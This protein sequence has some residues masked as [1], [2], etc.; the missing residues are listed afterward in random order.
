[1]RFSFYCRQFLTR[2]AL[3]VIAAVAVGSSCSEIAPLRVLIARR[4]TC[5][6][7]SSILRLR[8]LN[9]LCRLHC[10]LVGRRVLL[11]ALELVDCSRNEWVRKCKLR[12]ESL[13]RFPFCTLVNEVNKILI[14]ATHLGVEVLGTGYS[15]ATA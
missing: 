10:L 3:C 8:G 2:L 12:R 9:T 6:G 14:G 1:M 4:M 5:A 11:E 13:F 7:V 15:H